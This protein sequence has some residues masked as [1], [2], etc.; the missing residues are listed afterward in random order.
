MA[1]KAVLFISCGIFREE[2]EYLLRVKGLDWKIIYLDAALHVNFDRL[3]QKLVDALEEAQKTGAELKVIYGHCHPEMMDILKRYGAKKI[4]A[5]NCLQAM[6]GP[7][8][9]RRIDREAKAFFLTAGWANNVEKMFALAEKDFNMDMK[10]MFSSY[11]RIIVLD[12]GIIP[13][14]EEKVQR[15]STFTGLPVERRH[16][17]L[18]YLLNLVESI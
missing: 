9:M 11:K 18:D 16:I 2:L 4:R 3:K 12:S 15:F 8:E 1:K 14:D 17:T 5:K 7:Q 6:I 10:S 13:I